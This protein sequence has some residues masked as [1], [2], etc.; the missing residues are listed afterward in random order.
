MSTT[1]NWLNPAGPFRILRKILFAFLI[2]GFG[3]AIFAALVLQDPGRLFL[4]MLFI[5]TPSVLT[6]VG[7]L[8]FVDNVL[9]YLKG[10]A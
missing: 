7:V 5:V 9:A 10:G 4:L 1:H 2:L 8:W 6:L 3:S